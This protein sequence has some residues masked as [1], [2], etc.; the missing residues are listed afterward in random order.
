M[1]SEHIAQAGS[2]GQQYC[3]YHRRAHA[4]AL[5]YQGG[6]QRA[7]QTDER[8]ERQQHAE[9]VTAVSNHDADTFDEGPAHGVS[10]LEHEHGKHHANRR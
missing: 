5:A 8:L 3:Q 6:N 2:T 10:G 1:L 7:D 9:F 4:E